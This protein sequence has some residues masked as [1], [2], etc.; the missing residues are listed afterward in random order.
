[1]DNDKKIVRLLKR[2]IRLL[3]LK[4]DYRKVKILDKSSGNRLIFERIN[5]GKPTMIARGGAVELRC[6][7]QYLQNKT[8]T[9][10][11]R[12]EVNHCAGVFP[13]DDA[14]L[15]RFCKYYIQCMREAD[16]LAVWGVGAEKNIVLKDHKN[17]NLIE[18]EALEPYYFQNPWSEALEGKDVLVIHPFIQSI[19]NQYSK[20]ELL[21]DN[22]AVLPN[23]KSLQ[24]IK[25]VQSNAGEIVDFDDWF[26]AL[27]LMKRQIDEA[28]FD[29]AIIGAGAYSLPLAAYIKKNGKIAVQ[30]SGSTQILF[31]IKG[32]RWEN[33]PEVK[34]LFNEYWVYPSKNETPKKSELVEGGSYWR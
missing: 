33:I 5:Q 2:N 18:L 12:V 24:F 25:A 13:T 4:W 23:F 8:F 3:K 7:Q 17:I 6:V 30:M 20:K 27:E 32:K 14:M 1:M 19:K 11:M 26:G 31:G 29:V 16:I 28:Q 15:E 34:D 22:K 21:F 10:A 9:D